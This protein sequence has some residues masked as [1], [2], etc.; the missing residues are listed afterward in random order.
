MIQIKKYKVGF[1]T[2]V[3]GGV[4]WL[5]CHFIRYCYIRLFVDHLGKGT[6]IMRDFEIRSPKKIRI[7][8]HTIINKKVLL[9]GRGGLLTIGDNVSIGQET[10][11][12]T[13]EHDPNDNHFSSRGG[14]VVIEDYVWIATRCTILPGIKIGRGA[15]LASGTVVTKDVPPMSIVG[16]VPAKVI[17]LRTSELE[18]TLKRPNM[19]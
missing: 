8:N 1:W 4:M 17:G 15:V 7:G 13:L 14:D 5:P 2:F 11:I 9:D 3:T 12:W 6:C 10:N 16:G 18:Y 19:T